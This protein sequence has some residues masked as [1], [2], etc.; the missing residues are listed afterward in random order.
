MKK[1]QKMDGRVVGFCL[2]GK[3]VKEKQVPL[4]IQLENGLLILMIKVPS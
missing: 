2:I 3:G 1:K 4:S